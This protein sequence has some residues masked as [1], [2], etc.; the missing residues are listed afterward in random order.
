MAKALAVGVDVSD[1]EQV[2][3]AVARVAAELSA[4]R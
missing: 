2:G 1:E 3:A 4:P